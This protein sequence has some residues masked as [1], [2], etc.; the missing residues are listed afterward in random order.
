MV[1]PDGVTIGPIAGL[2]YFERTANANYHALQTR[3]EKRL[4]H[5]L[6]V[7]SS[8]TWSKNISDGRGAGGVGGTSSLTAQNPHLLSAERALSDEHFAH[9]FVASPIYQL[10]FGRG[11]RFL[12]DSPSAVNAL[13]GGWTLASIV[14]L[15]SGGRANLSVRGNPANTGTANRPNALRDWRLDSGTRSLD[16]WFDTDAFER[17]P[18]YTYG[19]AARNLIEAPGLVNLDL[20][21]YKAFSIKEDLTVQ[22]RAEAFNVSNTPAFSRPNTQVGNRNFGQIG[23]AG[24]PRNLQFGL[25]IIF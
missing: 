23:G 1:P 16:R 8:Y 22:F 4:T 3:L 20:A 13:L 14:T 10:P 9:R 12:T 7:L 21:I 5:G 19:N 17:N 2:N 11:K 24:R 6:S 25:K 15:Q 18:P